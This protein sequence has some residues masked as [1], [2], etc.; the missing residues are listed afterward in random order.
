MHYGFFSAPS[1]FSLFYLWLY[2]PFLGPWP[3]FQFLDPIHNQQGYLDGGSARRKAAAYTQ[4]NTKHRINV[5]TDIHALS[6]TLLSC[7]FIIAL[8]LSAV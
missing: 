3:L 7:L 4:N 5:H 6:G 8:A 1:Q 2:S